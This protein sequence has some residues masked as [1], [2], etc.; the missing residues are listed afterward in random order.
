M[1]VRFEAPTPLA[2]IA[3]VPRYSELVWLSPIFPAVPA[4]ESVDAELLATFEPTVLNIFFKAPNIPVIPARIP[5]TL[6]TSP[7]SCPPSA[8]PISPI[9]R[10]LKATLIVPRTN[11][12]PAEA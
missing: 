4:A 8:A 5:T 12:K 9:L 11:P 10:A 7:V 1:L 3:P 2:F 6:L